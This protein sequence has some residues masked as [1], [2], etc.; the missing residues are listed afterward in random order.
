MKRIDVCPP[1]LL[2]LDNEMED[3][4]YQ[5][6]LPHARLKQTTPEYRAKPWKLRFVVVVGLMILF[7]WGFL[8]A[9]IK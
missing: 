8:E 1:E 3:F 7:W 9:L 6:K 5:Q 4:L 2:S